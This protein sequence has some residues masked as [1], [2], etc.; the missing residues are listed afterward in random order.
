MH[1]LMLQNLIYLPTY[2]GANKANRLVLGQLAGR[3][4]RC[5]VV[6]P[7]A[8]VNLDVSPREFRHL[9]RR[10]GLHVLSATDEAIVFDDGGVEVH[11]V[12]QASR[13]P[14]YA[15]GMGRAA[16]PDLVL[17][18]TDDPAFMVLNSAFEA[19]GPERVICLVHT[20]S[21][22]PFGPEATVVSEVGT[23]QLRRAA[24]TLTVS[25][26]AADYL[27]EWGDLRATPLRLP[28]YGTGPFPRYGDPDSGAVTLVNPSPAKGIEMFLYL[29]ERLPDTEFL[30]VPTW[31]T[32]SEDRRALAGRPNVRVVDPVENIDEIL[33]RTR[34][35]LMPSRWAET[36]GMTAVEAMLRG[37]PVVASEVG[38]LP[39]AMSG[40]PYLLPALAEDAWLQAVT[41]LVS[42][43]A[44]YLEISELARE[45]T[46]S[47]VES[48]RIAE[49]EEYLRERIR[50]ARDSHGGDGPASDLRRRIENLPDTRRRLLAQLMARR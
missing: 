2:G 19:V 46:L 18:T 45:T 3:G 29:A 5:Q 15:T 6:A 13:L 39:E 42:D 30:A 28:A 11:A 34:V 8:G 24:G 37:I 1:L 20:L 33:A 27:D 12:V 21:Y 38:G 10:R 32:S 16:A 49:V 47:A 4:H 9:L 36:F 40:V 44:H 43:R 50:L 48:M 14:V 7:M 23:R 35:M 26:A 25:Q 31:G 17:V 41:R 22:L